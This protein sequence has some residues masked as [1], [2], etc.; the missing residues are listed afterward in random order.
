NIQ[1]RIARDGRYPAQAWLSGCSREYREDQFPALWNPDCDARW[2][3]KSR[4]K[5]TPLKN[6]KTLAQTIPLR[7]SI[8]SGKTR[9]PRRANASGSSNLG[10]SSSATGMSVSKR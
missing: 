2:L 7:S 8:G 6:E 4:V 9:S 1:D 10:R 5:V 3:T